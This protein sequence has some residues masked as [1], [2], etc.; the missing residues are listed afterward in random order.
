MYWIKETSDTLWD[1]QKKKNRN[2]WEATTH[3]SMK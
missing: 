1:N 2:S 3:Q